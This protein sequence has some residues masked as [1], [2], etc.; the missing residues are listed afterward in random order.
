MLMHLAAFP[1]KL[2]KLINVHWASLNQN[3]SSA[4][5]ALLGKFVMSIKQN[6]RQM[7]GGSIEY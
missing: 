4:R 7:L 5:L 1:H 6:G 2:L 3:Q